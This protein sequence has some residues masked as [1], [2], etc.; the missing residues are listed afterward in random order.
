MSDKEK[1]L[2]ITAPTSWWKKIAKAIALSTE[3]SNDTGDTTSFLSCALF[4]ADE[5]GFL[6][7]SAESGASK[8]HIQVDPEDDLVTVEGYGVFM[9]KSTDI[10]NSVNSLPEDDVTF[11]FYD[12]EVIVETSSGHISFSCP[13][14]S[15]FND[16][17]TP[18]A[19]HKFDK[20]S[21]IAVCD[22]EELLK[23]Y[24][25]GSTMSAEMSKDK[26]IQ[27]SPLH[28]C[29]ISLIEEG[30]QIF[31][32]AS[33]SAESF[34]STETEYVG[35]RKDPITSIQSLTQPDVMLQ[36][37]PIFTDSD[38]IAIGIGDN[39]H[40]HIEDDYIHMDISPLNLVNNTN[41]DKNVNISKIMRLVEP[42][43][44][45]RVVSVKVSSKEFFA[46]L[47]RAASVKS[48][49]LTLEITDTE[50]LMKSM[51]V[52]GR[53]PFHQTIECSTQWHDDDAH[54]YVVNINISSIR[55]ISSMVSSLPSISF[56]ISTYEVTSSAIPSVMVIKID[57][58][59]DHNDPHD[60]F[61]I[62]T[63]R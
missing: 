42:L 45:S 4:D 21:I 57:E 28:A 6:T 50:I 49:G 34:I 43:W 38:E 13:L 44:E 9:I 36:R 40:V 62:P 59:Y 7:I 48:D 5:D 55:K 30:I 31:S 58:E 10:T 15:I 19:S 29:A 20:N 12:R 27:L 22:G 46:A 52:D 47:S 17:A 8:T 61:V 18:Q 51:N 1:Q 56:D 60:F 63:I 25:A 37:I 14:I 35:K 33:S 54:K 11:S 41:A 16:D 26:D 32:F 2:N 39:R 53:T 3:K 24:R 23:K